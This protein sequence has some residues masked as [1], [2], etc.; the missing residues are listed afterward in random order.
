MAHTWVPNDTDPHVVDLLVAHWRSMALAERVEL[1]EQLCADTERLARAGIAAIHPEY[2][3]IE[4]ARELARRRYGD[5]IADAAY[6][7]VST[8]G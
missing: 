6:G 1:I 8:P 7:G 2:T 4:I 5:A 3:E